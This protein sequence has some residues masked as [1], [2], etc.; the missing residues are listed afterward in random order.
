MDVN[1]TTYEKFI[2]IVS[3]FTLELDFNKQPPVKVWYDIKKEYPKLSERIIK[4]V[5]PFFQ[6]MSVWD[7]NFLRYFN[8]NEIVLKAKADMSLQLSY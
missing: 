2:N 8:Q 3:D 4:E 5:L 6:L 1:V 7:K